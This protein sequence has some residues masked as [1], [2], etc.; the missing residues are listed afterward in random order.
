M[1]KKIG[2]FFGSFNPIHIGHLI[3]A[4]Y[5]V[6]HT[7]LKELWFV[8][9]PCNPLKKKQS[10]LNDHQRLYMVNDAIEVIKNEILASADHIDNLI[11]NAGISTYAAFDEYTP[12]VWENIMR[13]NVNVPVFLVQALKELMAENG[14]ILFMGSHAGQA[15]YSSS[16]VYSVSKAA[17]L[18]AAKSMVKIL[19][20]TIYMKN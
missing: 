2:L 1:K 11:L 3:I 12:E 16:L 17:M 14:S 15:T 13:T 5:I 6:E 8:V 9:S 7:D 4:E 20:L 10:M 19:L 18:F